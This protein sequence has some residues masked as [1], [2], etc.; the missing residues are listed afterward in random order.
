MCRYCR[1]H[2]GETPAQFIVHGVIDFLTS[3]SPRARALRGNVVFKIAPMLNPDGENVRCWA[4][5][6]LHGKVVFWL[7][8]FSRPHTA[9]S[10]RYSLLLLLLRLGLLRLCSH[11]VE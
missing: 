4:H 6:I 5:D 3:E 1:V 10:A 7:E 9:V 8:S 11:H 2:P